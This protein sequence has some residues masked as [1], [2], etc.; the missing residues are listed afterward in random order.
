MAEQE[1]NT[2]FAKVKEKSD[3]DY[4]K[5]ITYISA[6][7]LVVSLTFIE[8]IVNLGQSSAVWCL[9]TSWA[10]MGSTLL[11][12]LVSHQ[13]SSHYAQQCDEELRL[14]IAEE[15]KFRR[16]ITLIRRLNWTTTATLSLGMLFLI[17]FCSINA[18]HMSHEK[19]TG[20]KPET[21][22]SRPQNSE[23]KGRP[24]SIP[25]SVLI[26]PP[27]SVERP[28]GNTGQDHTPPKADN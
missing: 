1:E 28:Q 19:K 16:R 27:T 9:I 18:I 22:T 6:G 11:I 4:E 13:L 23:Q 5:N 15:P 24:I 14:S 20:Q 17:V 3:D 21:A 10:F 12:N 2:D 26:K 25:T 8:K 7:T